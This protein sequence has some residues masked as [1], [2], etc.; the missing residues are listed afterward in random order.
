MNSDFTALLQTVLWPVCASAFLLTGLICLFGRKWM[1]AISLLLV[2]LLLCGSWQYNRTHEDLSTLQLL[3]AGHRLVKAN[4]ARPAESVY[5]VSLCGMERGNW[6]V[7][8]P[9]KNIRLTR[10]GQIVLV[11]FGKRPLT[12]TYIKSVASLPEK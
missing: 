4:P 6:T 5:E 9:A 11:E 3:L 10:P 12:G 7:K 2:G 1:F 8:L